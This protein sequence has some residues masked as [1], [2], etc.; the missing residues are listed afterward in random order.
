MNEN[1]LQKKKGKGWYKEAAFQ[2]KKTCRVRKRKAERKNIVLKY[3]KVRGQESPQ[4]YEVLVQYNL[5]IEAL[6]PIP[7][8]SVISA[9]VE[10][11]PTCSK[12]HSYEYFIYMGFSRQA[13][14]HSP[15]AALGKVYERVFILGKVGSSIP[16]RCPVCVDALHMQAWVES[17]NGCMLFCVDCRGGEVMIRC[18]FWGMVG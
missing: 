12:Q 11:V 6:F 14:M 3:H 1:L 16:G 10:M 13:C 2:Q 18:Y 17:E 5:S 9:A 8:Q 7:F 4:I 15:L